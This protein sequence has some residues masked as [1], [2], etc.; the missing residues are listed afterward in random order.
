MIRPR[1][2]HTRILRHQKGLPH[3]SMSGTAWW[4][5]RC[6]MVMLLCFCVMLPARV[7]VRAATLTPNPPLVT[8][9]IRYHM[10]EAGEV[11]LIWGING[12]NVVPEENR[13]AGTAV[14]DRVMHTPMAREGDTFVAQVQVPSGTT[15]DYGF[16]TT[17]TYDGA[18]VYLWE[19]DGDQDYHIVVTQDGIVE[20]Q[21]TLTLAQDQP[22]AGTADTLPV[23]QEIRYHMPEA[24]EVFLI[25]G[26]DGWCIVPE[27]DRPAGTVVKK[28]VMHTPMVHTGDAFIAQVQV[29][30]GA[31]LDYGFLITKKR[32][33]AAVYVWEAD[34]DQDYHITATQ[35]SLINIQTSL[36]L[37]QNQTLK[38]VILGLIAFIGPDI[39]TAFGL[40]IGVGGLCYVIIRR[41]FSS[42]LAADQP[43]TPASPTQPIS[44]VEACALVIVMVI[45]LVLRLHGLTRGLSFDELYT[46][47]HFIDAD[48]LWATISTYQVFNNH[49]AYSILGRF[50]QALLGR[51]EWVLRLPALMLGLSSIVTLW[52]LGRGLL[53]PR[54]AIVSALG[55]A[56]SPMHV[57]YSESARGYT[58]LTLFTLISTHLYLKLL[59]HPVRRDGLIFVL[60][61]V[62]GTYFH[63]YG[64]WV[65]VVQ[66]VFLLYLAITQAACNPSGRHLG[67]KSF[68][69]LWSSFP[70]IG[71]LSFICYAPVCEE[72]LGTIH[73][74]GNGVL[75]WSFPLGLIRLL[76]GTG[77]A[78]GTL[79]AGLVVLG[80]I[81]HR[82]SHTWETEY[83][84]LLLLAPLLVSWLLL[85]PADLY[86]RFFIYFLPYY[87]LFLVSGLSALWHFTTCL[88]RRIYGVLL[89]TLIG[90][91]AGLIL[92]SWTVNSWR[93]VPSPE[94]RDAIET[95]ET[96]VGPS[97]MLCAIG[98]DAEMFQYY[99]NQPLVIPHSMTEF[100]QFLNE[101][102]EV[103]CAYHD[104]SWSSAEHEQMA[105]FLAQNAMPPQIYRGDTVVAV[106]T[107]RK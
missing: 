86:V 102:P 69:L 43:N 32:N 45:A 80:L 55:L 73:S 56:L 90:I 54:M 12:W 17:K 65:T 10:P 94:Y 39:A 40:L 13:P 74:R 34:G 77:L 48:S 41:Y 14:K 51:S 76:G 5:L 101:T 16:L 31:T 28:A 44:T 87:V 105:K 6:M 37:T 59:K 21:T 25:W 107:Y 70:A 95:M 91:S 2:S 60:A 103:R 84:V 29:P 36:K 47:Y 67:V 92:C 93:I 20:V 82:H 89:R 66:F 75:E 61:S 9:E 49:V 3:S 30:A 96:G 62:I 106:Y 8:L 81:S 98:G 85:R 35:D 50:G 72:L 83:V 22:P 88:H 46:A 42:H 79:L 53:G 97:T 104:V 15:I 99:A 1:E 38:D 24:G 26:I 64:I 23:I 63:L 33:G 19:A 18:A 27:E 57:L 68:R 7:H 58:G 78:L 52:I 71:I 100:Y 4:L 11:F